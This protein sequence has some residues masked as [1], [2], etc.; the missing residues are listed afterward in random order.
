MQWLDTSERCPNARDRSEAEDQSS[1]EG[2]QYPEASDLILTS[3]SG[4]T[5]NT[6]DAYGFQELTN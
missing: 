4:P 2:D 1:D 3:L 5:R 6:R